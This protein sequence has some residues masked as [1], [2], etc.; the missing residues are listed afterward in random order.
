MGFKHDRARPRPSR[1]SLRRRS[2]APRAASH[3]G[4]ALDVIAAAAAA[5]AVFRALGPQVGIKAEVRSA[6]R[7]AG[8]TPVDLSPEAF[9]RRE[10]GRGR[11]ARSPAQIPPKGW[12]DVIWRVFQGFNGDRV[13][14]V[15][16]GVTFFTLL[17]VFPAIAAFVSVYGL[18]WD[19][20]G[21]GQ[22]LGLLAGMLPAGV[23]DFVRAQMTF[24]AGH[25]HATLSFTFG[26]SLLLSLWSANASVKA[27]LYGLNIAYHETE[28][29]NYLHYTL[30]TL[31]LTLG[32]LAFVI[33]ASA[34]VVATPFIVGA[35]NYPTA[36]LRADLLR[37][38]LL[39][40]GYVAVLSLLYRFG[41]CR[42]RARWRWLTS[43]GVIAAV[44]SLIV[45]WLFSTYLGSA[46]RYDR[47]YG[48]LG[49]IMGF[50]IWTWWS[51]TVVLVGAE[52]NA[53]LE[54]QTAI[55]TTTGE[56]LPMGQRGAIVA[57]TVGP[58][59]GGPAWANYTLQ[60][61]MELSREYLRRYGNRA[62]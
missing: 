40:V 10:P 55:D 20:Q 61:A 23:L 27:L 15:A 44:L 18:F 31:G 8:V 26:A 46:A 30:L 22:T 38:P 7:G 5:F 39:F 47:T 11:G 57:D 41:P 59:R 32:L 6:R 14:F 56:P 36:L 45:S 12:I 34:L 16:G 9:E 3:I 48:P 21:A 58:P 62:S 60:G 53:E 49:A 52:I 19:A 43:G 35:L 42:Q 28:K 1:S 54:H 37:W 17:A 13:M 33:F 29:R 4:A 50:M 2:Q 24:V 51:V 25:T